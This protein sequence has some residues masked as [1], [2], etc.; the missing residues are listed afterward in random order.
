ML[1]SLPSDDVGKSYNR[2][3]GFYQGLACDLADLVD[4]IVDVFIRYFKIVDVRSQ[5]V[6][7]RVA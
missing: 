7:N 6:L 2:L 5:I 4:G 3:V 1:G